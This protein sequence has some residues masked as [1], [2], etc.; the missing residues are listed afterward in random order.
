[1][2]LCRRSSADPCRGVPV[3]QAPRSLAL[4]CGR[5]EPGLALGSSE[6]A[7]TGAVP[8]ASPGSR[9]HGASGPAA[10]AAGSGAGGGEATAGLESSG[11]AELS[12]HPKTCPGC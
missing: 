11:G 9:G 3:E 5:G 12:S 2:G 8:A 6:P 1:M 10:L 4:R 7:G